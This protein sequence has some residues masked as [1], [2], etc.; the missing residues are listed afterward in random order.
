MGRLGGGAERRSHCASYLANIHYCFCE[1]PPVQIP[2]EGEH[3]TYR[4]LQQVV[5]LRNHLFQLHFT[6]EK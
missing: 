3:E 5:I 6:D 1:L 4:M 2:L